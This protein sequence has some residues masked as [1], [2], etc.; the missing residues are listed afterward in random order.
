M[1]R[2]TI[3]LLQQF[4]LFFIG[5]STYATN[6]KEAGIYSKEEISYI[7]KLQEDGLKIGI[8]FGSLYL[9]A[10]NSQDSLANKYSSLLENFFHLDVELVKEE[11]GAIYSKLKKE[12]IDLLL[13][14]TLAEE[15]KEEFNLSIPIYE[16]KFYI[17]SNNKDIPL[18]DWNDL[19]GEEIIVISDSFY[20][21]YLKKFK[22]RNNLNF[23]IK[24]VNSY[25][26]Y[27]KYDFVAHHAGDPNFHGL[28]YLELGEL[29]PL[30]IGLAKNNFELK[31]IIDKALEFSHKDRLLEMLQ[32]EI[33]KRKK[34]G[35]YKNL[36]ED[37]KN[38][39]KNKTD[40]EIVMD[41]ESYPIFF[42][43][44]D[45]KK[46]DGLALRW[47]NE[48][49]ILLDKPI[50]VINQ[51]PKESWSMV[52]NR[53]LKG[54]GDITSMYYTLER[55]RDK[56]FS[57]P[58]AYSDIILISNGKKTV[59][60]E[61]IDDMRIGAVKDDISEVIALKY[62]SV[63]NDV[64]RY[65]KFDEMIEALK[66][67]SIDLCVMNYEM[68]M[69]YHQTRFDLSL[70]MEKKLEKK[71]ISFVVQG[72]NDLL[73]SIVNKAINGFIDHKNI[74][75]N[76]FLELSTVKIAKEREHDKH[77]KKNFILTMFLLVTIITTFIAANRHIST[78]K[79]EKIAYYDHLTSALNRLSFDEAMNNIDFKKDRGLG[80]Y[81]DLNDFKAINDNHG[82]HVGDVVL[83]EA[84]SRLQKVFQK[85]M[86]YRLAGDEFFIFSKDISLEEG[87]KLAAHALSELNIPIFSLE[88][89]I[90]I[91]ASIGICELNE[92]IDNLDYFMHKADIAMY[93]AKKSGRGSIV[94]A[95]ETMVDEFEESK[96]LEKALKLSLQKNEIVPYFQPKVNL[97]TNEIIGLEALARWIHPQKG[98]MSP[99]TF[100]PLAEDIGIVYKL[101]MKIAE[102][103]IKTIKNWLDQGFISKNFKAS[104]NVSAQT[105][106]E[107][108]VYEQI[109]YF[110]DKYDVSGNLIEI[111]LTESIFV[112]KFNKVLRELNFIKDTLGASVA[113]DDFTAGYSSLRELNRF[114]IDA[115]KFDKSLLQS[116]KENSEKG[117]K[118]YRTLINLCSDLEYSSVAEGIEELHEKEFLEKEGVTYAQGFYFGKPMPEKDF[119]EL[120][121]K[122]L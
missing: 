51:S 33:K 18:N 32:V 108:N 36:S 31:Q 100:I 101:D 38:Y 102:L 77:K 50:K 114:N 26:N 84:V 41:S 35:F 13:N 54:E 21:D 11:W 30:G 104:F 42:Y 48:L 28:D 75:K 10:E 118:I 63:N 88:S 117:K 91:G 122:G 57:K 96:K 3:I 39:I 76:F 1:K 110:L 73:L 68:F 15:R 27:S 93:K 107:I 111:E 61:N 70:E 19:I 115:L 113:L 109:K 58:L 4:I 79:A 87:I 7:E 64:I 24:E 49:S 62:F 2:A 74:S 29:P 71:A 90:N 89:S 82:H 85:D 44:E 22:K 83:K 46:Y 37:E 55:G 12:E 9:D 5:I 99:S 14:F 119:L 17:V 16:D 98:I 103:T 8:N 94:I 59:N 105:F 43:N 53:F 34:R 86:V 25:N 81:I 52:Y 72:G 65:I 106:E 66:N 112:N 47:M 116:V 121:N 78:H 6:Y 80:M 120:L 56:N 67:G 92:K 23:K 97:Q 60:K 69:Y 40:I 20:S 45:K 95:T